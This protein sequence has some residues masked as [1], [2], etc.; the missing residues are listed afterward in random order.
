MQTTFSFLRPYVYVFT[1]AVALVLFLTTPAFGQPESIVPD[2]VYLWPDGAP[3]A[4]GETPA[5]R[6]TL[7]LFFPPEEKATGTGVVI[8]PGGGYTHLA[9][10]K[11]GFKVAEW[12]NERGVAAFVLKYRLG[13][14]Y[15]YPAQ[16]QD[17]QRALRYVRYHAE[18][19]GL[20][21]DR[22]GVMGFSAGGHLA[23]MAA[24]LF[25]ASDSLVTTP[26][27]IDRVSAR[28]DFAVLAYPVITLIGPYAHAGSRKM[29]LGEGFDPTLA[30]RL[31]VERRVT[32]ETP[33]TFL[34]STNED[35]GVPAENSVSFYRALRDHGVPAELHIYER[36]PHGVGLAPGNPVL[37]S[38]TDRLEDWLR[39]H[40]LLAP[41]P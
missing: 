34:F 3:G 7:A 6:P 11:E 33:P 18:E 15:H 12:F 30:R 22:I 38:W 20:D 39:V 4:L 10:E 24:T 29:L 1:G 41:T 26:D 9:M 14:R 17:V 36:G 32:S 21:P 35:R 8:C 19:W 31:S 13:P 37:S 25:D 40:G 23:A 5:D 27:A 28:P 2:S 16:L